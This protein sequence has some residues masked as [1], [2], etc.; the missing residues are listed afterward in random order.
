MLTGLFKKET[1]AQKESRRLIE[2]EKRMIPANKVVALPQYGQIIEATVPKDSVMGRFYNRYMGEAEAVLSRLAY[3]ERIASFKISLEA[4]GEDLQK[5]LLDVDDPEMSLEDA[6]QWAL[7]RMNKGALDVGLPL[8]YE[9]DGFNSPLELI[10]KEKFP[11]FYLLHIVYVLEN[12]AVFGGNLRKHEDM[13]IASN[14]GYIVLDFWKA[15]RDAKD[16]GPTIRP[17]PPKP[18]DDGGGRTPVTEKLRGLLGGLRPA[19][20]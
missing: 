11:A 3:D 8:P 16:C 20:G 2:R 13:A 12:T 18:P 15:V 7:A 17:N 6:Y 10:K 14:E 9:S 5:R 4:F 19:H 1:E